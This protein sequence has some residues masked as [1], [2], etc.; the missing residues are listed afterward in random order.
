MKVLVKEEGRL[1]TRLLEEEI[2]RQRK[3]EGLKP[4]KKKPK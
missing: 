4:L 3:E 1:Y 2:N